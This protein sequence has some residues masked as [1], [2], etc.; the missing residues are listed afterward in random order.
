M[1]TLYEMEPSL[2]DVFV[3]GATD[4]GFY[5]W[6][7]RERNVEAE[8]YDIDARVFIGREL[9]I[10]LGIEVNARGRA[11]ALG[12]EAD[13]RLGADQRSV[14]IVVDADFSNALGKQPGAG[15]AVLYTDVPALESYA[16]HE[17]PM[18]KFLRVVLHAP[19]TLKASAVLDV[20]TPVLT[21]V[22]ATRAVLHSHAVPLI[23]N[24]TRVCT[25]EESGGRVRVED[26]LARSI[27]GRKSE[28]QKTLEDLVSEVEEASRLM[29]STGQYARGHD[30]APVLKEFLRLKGG[31]ANHDAIEA[32]LRASLPL[33]YLDE[34][35][36]FMDLRRRLTA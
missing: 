26:L 4:R 29:K 2:R 27:G 16:L 21:V 22:L 32:G 15:G 3:E 31:L 8:V 14:T 23:Q 6:Y 11:I 7:L 35:P 28:L 5:G 12:V 34:Q 17:S 33:D 18:E 1:L 36:L 9:P 24:F 13:A 25:F 10:R 30:I 20:I 19:K